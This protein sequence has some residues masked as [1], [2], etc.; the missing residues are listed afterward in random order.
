MDTSTKPLNILTVAETV[1]AADK[2]Q[3][4]DSRY[5]ELRPL[6]AVANYHA[7]KEFKVS[8]KLAVP[9]SKDVTEVVCT[10][11]GMTV[12]MVLPK[13]PGF[14]LVYENPLSIYANVKGMLA[15][16]KDYLTTLDVQVLAGIWLTAYKHYDLLVVSRER[17]PEA[18][19]L[20][21]MLRTA[22]KTI[23]VDGLELIDHITSKNKDNL[24]H[25]SLEYTAHKEFMSVGPAL[26]EYNRSMRNVIYPTAESFY[27]KS[28]EAKELREIEAAKYQDNTSYVVKATKKL[29]SSAEKDYEEQ[30]ILNRREAKL[31]LARMTESRTIP[32]SFIMKLKPVFVGKNLCTMSEATR[33]IVVSK[34]QSYD[35]ADSIRLAVIVAEGSDPYDID[36]AFDESAF[37]NPIGATTIVAKPVK[38]LSLKEIL[39]AKRN[40]PKAVAPV[41]EEAVESP[42][43][44]EIPVKVLR[45]TEEDAV[46]HEEIEES[47]DAGNIISEEDAKWNDAYLQALMSQVDG[48]KTDEDYAMR[49]DIDGSE[50]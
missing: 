32:S 33:K 19:A 11:T 34:L 10:K 6:H 39:E 14:A 26:Q 3:R 15:K 17:T 22:G 25:F 42:E 27:S 49:V 35:T 2:K 37:V 5:L 43:E 44:V 13:I 29:R 24:P 16:G 28:K 20:N 7:V 45:Y 50:F 1:L 21:A 47:L 40:P 9:A 18:V 4:D 8:T 30:F 31:I 38:K 23:L 48:D 36:D 41:V 46:R 12:L